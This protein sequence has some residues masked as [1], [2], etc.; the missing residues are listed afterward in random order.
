MK[1]L[2]RMS[3]LALVLAAAGQDFTASAEVP[4]FLNTAMYP[5][6]GASMEV[7][8]DV[9][10]DGILDIITANGVSPSGDGGVS[11]LLGIG[12]GTFHDAKKIV[13]GGSPSAVVVADFNNDGKLDIAVANEPN[14]ALGI[15]PVGGPAPKSVSIL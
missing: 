7:L 9:N 14:A 15:V 1:P 10:G 8:A 4:R 2:F 12:N 3:L 11:V 5:V 6:P 13:S